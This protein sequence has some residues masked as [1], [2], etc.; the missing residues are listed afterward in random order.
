M[1]H[2]AVRGEC[3]GQP[4][5]AVSDSRES[6]GF[7]LLVPPLANPPPGSLNFSGFAADTTVIS[8]RVALWRF[9]LLVRESGAEDQTD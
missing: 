4:G 2:P 5:V 6:N 8:K 3:V 7:S 1:I 9:G